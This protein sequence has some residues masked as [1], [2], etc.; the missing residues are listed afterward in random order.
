MSFDKNPSLRPIGVGEEVRG[1]AGKAVM[2]IV[3]DDVTKTVGNLQ[4]CGG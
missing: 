4:L 1:K 2:S 3:K